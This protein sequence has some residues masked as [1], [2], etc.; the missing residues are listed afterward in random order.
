MKKKFL[1][2][3][4]QARQGMVSGTREQRMES[5]NQLTSTLKSL[6]AVAENLS[7]FES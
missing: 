3:L 6:F 2:R 7:G 1:K 5:S 4:R